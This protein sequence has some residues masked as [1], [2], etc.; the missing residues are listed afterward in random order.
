M[1]VIAV[2]TKASNQ[3]LVCTSRQHHTIPAYLLSPP[4]S[5]NK[6]L[7]ELVE[8]HRLINED[9]AGFRRK[10]STIDHIFTLLAPV[11]RQLFSHGK[12]SVDFIDFKKA[13]DL[14]DRSCLWAVL[15]KNGIRGNMYR[16]IQSMYNA[17]KARVL[18]GGDITEA[19]VCPRGLKQG[20]VCSLILF[21]LFINELA[22]EIMQNGKHGITL[23]PEL[24]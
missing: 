10:Y 6:R 21:S 4:P 2:F 19:F 24:I 13:F 11:Q 15:R 5:L 3:P 23:S 20:D 16:A 9:Q 1:S 14:V 12:L 8:E 7:M 18:T 17:V 22:N